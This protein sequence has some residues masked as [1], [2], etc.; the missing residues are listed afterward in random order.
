MH[1]IIQEDGDVQENGE[2][3]CYR[4]LSLWW[5]RMLAILLPLCYRFDESAKF[6]YRLGG[7]GIFATACYE[8]SQYAGGTR[9]PRLRMIA[10][11]GLGLAYLGDSPLFLWRWRESTFFP[12]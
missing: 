11:A 5:E 10:L 7:R 12:P 1:L 4:L 8:V 2:N 3:F 9:L 6:C